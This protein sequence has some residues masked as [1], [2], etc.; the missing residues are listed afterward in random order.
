MSLVT[1]KFTDCWQGDLHGLH[2]IGLKITREKAN[3][4]KKFE[5]IFRCNNAC[6]LQELVFAFDNLNLGVYVKLALYSML[7]A[8]F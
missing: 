4:I 8:L 6:R 2:Q 3:T 5:Y 1:F 7:V